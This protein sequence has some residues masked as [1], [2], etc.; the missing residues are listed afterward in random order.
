MTCA[1][2]EAPWVGRAPAG[3]LALAMLVASCSSSRNNATIPAGPLT[4]TDVVTGLGQTT[5]LAFLPGGRMVITEKQ[6]AV[7]VRRPDGSL[8]IAATF[9]VDDA[10]EKGMLGVAVGYAFFAATGRIFLYYSASDATGGTDLDRHRDVR[11]GGY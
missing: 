1:D 9:D 11:D 4:L 3:A 2:A 5:D 8:T 10:S 6:G 7:K